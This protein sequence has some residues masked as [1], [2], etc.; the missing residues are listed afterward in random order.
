MLLT[1]R[2]GGAAF[3]LL[4]RN[5]FDMFGNPPEVA[6]P[7]ADAGVQNSSIQTVVHLPAMTWHDA[8]A[9]LEHVSSIGVSLH[10]W[11]LSRNELRVR[12]EATYREEVAWR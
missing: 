11:R 8:L 1:H 7:I 10:V 2:V 3:H 9:R 4:R 6:A 5:L 12:V